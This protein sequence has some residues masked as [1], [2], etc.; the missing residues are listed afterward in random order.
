MSESSEDYPSYHLNN[1]GDRAAFEKMIRKMMRDGCEPGRILTLLPRH[2]IDAIIEAGDGPR[3]V[4][5][6]RQ[7]WNR[8]R[9]GSRRRM[10]RHWRGGD[11]LMFGIIPSPQIRL[12]NQTYLTDRLSFGRRDCGVTG[13]LGHRI[14]FRAKDA[15]A[16]PDDVL[17]DLIA[18]ELAH[19]LQAAEGIHCVRQYRDGRADYADA[20]GEYWGGNLEIEE[21]A[22]STMLW[23][24]FDPE[25]I[26][27]WALATGRAKV[28]EDTPENRRRVFSRILRRGR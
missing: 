16:M 26:D 28:L 1:P 22:D 2:K 12:T 17:Q 6:F 10:L 19:V 14:T 20:R 23:W 18:H 3:F 27:R 4:R 13:A 25:S 21:D 7:A 9:L 15:D 11:G 8:I 24:G 5:L